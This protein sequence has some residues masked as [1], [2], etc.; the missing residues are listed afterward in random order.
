MRSTI[1]DTDFY[2]EDKVLLYDGGC[3]YWKGLVRDLSE[4]DKQEFASANW[5]LLDEVEEAK[6]IFVM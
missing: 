1:F 3:L 6:A 4:A 5:F 2:P